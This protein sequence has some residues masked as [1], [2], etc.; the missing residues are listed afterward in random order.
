MLFYETISNTNVRLLC[1][2]KETVRQGKA[3]GGA[4]AIFLDTITANTSR[5][6]KVT[7]T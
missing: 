6:E 4:V 1:L 3:A 7:K 5:A 2:R